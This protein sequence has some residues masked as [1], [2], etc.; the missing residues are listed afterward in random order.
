[1]ASHTFKPQKILIDF[2]W[3]AVTPSLCCP[4]IH[5]NHFILYRNRYHRQRFPRR[6]EWAVHLAFREMHQVDL[7]HSINLG[8]LYCRATFFTVCV[9]VPAPWV[10]HRSL[11]ISLIGSPVTHP[12]YN[13]SGQYTAPVILFAFLIGLQCSE[14]ARLFLVTPGNSIIW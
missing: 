1:M 14:S 12:A 4:V 11:P 13:A 9:S 3:I 7:C 8:S 5:S 2:S 10:H 6:N